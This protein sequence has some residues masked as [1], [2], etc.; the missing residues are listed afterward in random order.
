MQMFEHIVDTFID[1]FFPGFWQVKQT[2]SVG[3][4]NAP[5]KGETFFGDFKIADCQKV[6]IQHNVVSLTALHYIP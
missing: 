1:L 2:M 4:K 3:K 5:N 6:E